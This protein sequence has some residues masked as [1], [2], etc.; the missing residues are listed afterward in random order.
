[1]KHCKFV[2]R[3]VIDGFE[4][5]LHSFHKINGAIIWLMLRLVH[6]SLLKHI[7]EFLILGRNFML[8]HGL[9]FGEGRT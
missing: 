6:I 1:M 4:W 8:K 7:L 5:R 2:L 9:T 3:Q